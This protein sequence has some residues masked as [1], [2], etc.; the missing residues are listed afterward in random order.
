MRVHINHYSLRAFVFYTY[1]VHTPHIVHTRPIHS[2]REWGPL[3]ALLHK[4]REC[5][6]RFDCYLHIQFHHLP[7]AH[8]PQHQPV[9][10]TCIYSKYNDVFIDMRTVYIGAETTT[11]TARTSYQR[12][13]LQFVII[14]TT[15]NPEDWINIHTHTHTHTGMYSIRAHAHITHPY[16]HHQHHRTNITTHTQPY[17]HTHTH[18]HRKNTKSYTQHVGTD[19]TTY[20]HVIIYIYTLT[21]ILSTDP[22]THNDL[23]ERPVFT[24]TTRW[25]WYKTMSTH[26]QWRYAMSWNLYCKWGAFV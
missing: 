11:Q 4:E 2:K 15:N 26:A 13:T 16:E 25:C 8:Q 14:H 24:S 22:H 12:I 5:S 3:R 7:T 21:V 20:T 9:R 10:H 18:T 6:A 17:T 23:Q 1:Y 19:I